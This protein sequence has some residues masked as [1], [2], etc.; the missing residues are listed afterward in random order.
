M[1][2]IISVFSFLLI[3]SAISVQAQDFKRLEDINSTGT[4]YNI[5]AKE[6]E[7]T[8][9]VLVIS[10]LG[11]SGIYEIGGDVELDQLLALMGVQTPESS[12]ETST[13]ITVRLFREGAGRRELVYEASL[14]EM[15]T[16][17]GQYPPLREDDLVAIET[18][19]RTRQPIDFIEGVRLVSSLAS[20]FLL[21]RSLT[22]NNN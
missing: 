7:A 20:I 11:N 18:I 10:D 2:G 15:L 14:E 4:S 19:T 21:I 22:E 1:K 16:E 5:F 8:F 9:Q 13:K 6:G 12:N 17:P 3:V